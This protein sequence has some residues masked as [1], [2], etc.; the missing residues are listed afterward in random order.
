[1]VI[2]RAVANVLM[3]DETLSS[4]LEIPWRVYVAVMEGSAAETDGDSNWARNSPQFLASLLVLFY[5][6]AWLHS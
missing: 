6:R 2:V 1:M 4:W 3:P 5:F